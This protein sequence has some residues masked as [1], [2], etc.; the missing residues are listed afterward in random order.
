[1]KNTT[2]YLN[3]KTIHGVE[4]VDEVSSQDFPRWSDFTKEISRLRDEY[5][6]CGMNVYSSSR[7]TK[8]WKEKE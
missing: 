2:R 8:E 4:T 1:M 6:F 7:C 5:Y 3:L